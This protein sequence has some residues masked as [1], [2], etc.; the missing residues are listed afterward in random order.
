MR[1][2]GGGSG[3]ACHS[4]G[5]VQPAGMRD[6]GGGAGCKGRGRFAGAPPRQ[7]SGCASIAPPAPT[8]PPPSLSATARPSTAKARARARASS[9]ASPTR[10]PAT[11]RV[12]CAGWAAACVR[13]A[14]CMCAPCSLHAC[15]VQ[16]RRC[17]A[18][19]ASLPAPRATPWQAVHAKPAHMHVSRQARARALARSATSH[20][21]WTACRARHIHA[22]PACTPP[23]LPECTFAPRELLLQQG[24]E[25]RALEGA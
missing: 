24:G 19:H 15:A 16:P 3:A 10:A 14:A 18:R 8:H 2:R 25:E 23:P 20:V 12:R 7:D 21:V 1:G 22:L 13:H 17:H 11:T 6:P 9:C 5:A 4:V